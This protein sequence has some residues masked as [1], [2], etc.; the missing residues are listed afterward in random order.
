MVETAYTKGPLS[1][2]GRQE[3]TEISG[4][5]V[6][7]RSGF[8]GGCTAYVSNQDD[9]NLYAA[10]PD[11]LEVAELVVSWLDEEEGAHALCDKAREAISKAT[12]GK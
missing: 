4:F 12:G 1:V 8:Q 7:G 6:I 10:S 2:W 3:N 9:A 5:T 11:L